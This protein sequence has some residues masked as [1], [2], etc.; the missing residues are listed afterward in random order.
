MHW[1]FDF[2]TDSLIKPKSPVSEHI[3]VLNL[4]DIAEH[5]ATPNANGGSQRGDLMA[6]RDEIKRP[7]INTESM[8]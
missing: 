4:H 6:K 3:E 8:D 5:T 1:G 2:D 7:S